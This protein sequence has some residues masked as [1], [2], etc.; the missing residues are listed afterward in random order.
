[1]Q[2]EEQNQKLYSLSDYLNG[3]HEILLYLMRKKGTALMI[4]DGKTELGKV[5]DEDKKALKW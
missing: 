4:V 2:R 5:E 1:M 3:P